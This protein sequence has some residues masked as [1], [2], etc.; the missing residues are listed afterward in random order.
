MPLNL[1]VKLFFILIELFP[2]LAV[3]GLIQQLFSNNNVTDIFFKFILK[4]LNHFHVS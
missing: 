3:Y 1:S 2:Q 4:Y